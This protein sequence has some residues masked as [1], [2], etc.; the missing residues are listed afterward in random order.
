MVERACLEKVVVPLRLLRFDLLDLLR[1]DAGHGAFRGPRITSARLFVDYELLRNI[2]SILG[3]VLF[4]ESFERAHRPQLLWLSL[5]IF[6]DPAVITKRYTGLL[7]VPD[8]TGPKLL[9]VLYL[10]T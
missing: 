9:I 4:T 10:Q 3:A 7:S 6:V 5:G 1:H 2:A 8:Y